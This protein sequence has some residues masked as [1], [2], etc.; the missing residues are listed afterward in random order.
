MLRRTSHRGCASLRLIAVIA[1]TAAALAGNPGTSAGDEPTED[2]E[3][4]A[5]YCIGVFGADQASLKALLVPACLT[6]EPAPECAARI[7][8]IDRDRHRVDY[9]LRRLQDSF[10]THGIVAPERY[11]ALAKYLVATSCWDGQ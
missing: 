2:S 11:L 1:L 6:N 4:L 9:T 7:A 8:E 5:A 3:L 10:A